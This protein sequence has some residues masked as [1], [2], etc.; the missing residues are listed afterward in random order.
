MFLTNE[1]DYAIL[2]PNGTLSVLKK[3]EY[4]PL[5]RKD[6]NIKAKSSG[7][8]TEIVY[9]GVLFEDNLKK[10]GKDKKW[11]IKQL[12]KYGVREFSEAFLVT[13]NDSGSL[14]VDKYNDQIKMLKI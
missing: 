4:L 6:M 5:N 13:L 8:S 7:I 11:L 12:K 2:E 10:M 14:Y 9:D 1:V 3:S